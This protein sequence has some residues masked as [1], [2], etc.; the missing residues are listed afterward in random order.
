MNRII[1]KE[2]IYK[3]KDT[4]TQYKN[5]INFKVNWFDNNMTITVPKV[6]QKYLISKQALIKSKIDNAISEINEQIQWMVENDE[7][8]SFTVKPSMFSI[9][10]WANYKFELKYLNAPLPLTMS[11]YLILKKTASGREKIADKLRN[12]P[13]IHI[14]AAFGYPNDSNIY[15]DEGVDHT[16]RINIYYRLDIIQVLLGY[17][18]YDGDTE[19]NDLIKVALSNGNKE[20]YATDEYKNA[21]NKINDFNVK[22]S[23]GTLVISRRPLVHFYSEYDKDGN[24]LKDPAFIG[25]AYALMHFYNY[26]ILKIDTTR[27]KKTAIAS[28]KSCDESKHFGPI[29]PTKTNIDVEIYFSGDRFAKKIDFAGCRAEVYAIPY[30]HGKFQWHLV[31]EDENNT[32]PDFFRHGCDESASKQ[33]GINVMNGTVG[34]LSTMYMDID[35]NLDIIKHKNFDTDDLFHVGYINIEDLKYL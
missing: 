19:R 24:K 25:N 9:D 20:S 7:F 14:T 18:K 2:N 22:N 1:L 29:I 12:E 3:F 30:S 31:R 34:D 27:G 23:T 33:A 5:K 26:F 28:F 21:I 4:D 11:E 13:H 10:Y 17:G 6:L 8:D 16:I 32:I 35:K 15:P